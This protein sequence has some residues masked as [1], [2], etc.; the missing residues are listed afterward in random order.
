MD[1]KSLGQETGFFLN[2]QTITHLQ[3]TGS[4]D[5]SSEAL[6][7]PEMIGA[8]LSEA[9]FTH[10]V[11]TSWHCFAADFFRMV[12]TSAAY[13]SATIYIYTLILFVWQPKSWIRLTNA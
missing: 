3:P 13:V 4:L 7:I 6:H 5:C 9:R 8:N 2:G 12:V 11:G 10:Q 1:G